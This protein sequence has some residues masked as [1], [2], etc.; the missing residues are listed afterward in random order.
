MNK[1]KGASARDAVGMP[2]PPASVVEM[3]NRFRNLMGRSHSKMQ[4][5]FALVLERLFGLIDNKM[6]GLL[7]ELEIPD[8]LHGTP[9][10]ADELARDTGADADALDRILRFLVSRDLL[11]ITSDGRYKNNKASEL[12]RDE[13]PYS[14]KG[15]VEFFASGWNWDIWGEAMHS[16]MK[17]GGAAEAALGMPFFDY[18]NDNSEA[19]TAFNAAMQSGSTMQG[20]LVQEKYDFSRSQHICDVGGGTG[21]VLG[22]LLATNP[23][24]R[25]TLFELPAV[26]E[27]ARTHLDSLRLLDR[28]EVVGGDFFES[29]PVKADIYTLFAVVH[30]WGDEEAVRILENIRR[31]MPA[32]GRVLVIEGVIPDHSHYNFSKVSDLLMLV[33]SDAGRERTGEEFDNLFTRAGFRVQ[34]VLTLPSLFRI[35]ELVTA[36]S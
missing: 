5:P 25:G 29:I 2:L 15:W 22:N 27:E 31:A 20:L 13:H 7:V 10:S 33:Y 11:G 24:L 4:P 12:L 23:Q 36:G 30:D 32:D 21:A 14:W 18:L 8:L 3:A 6:L 19:G 34:R 16:V 28:C 26:A 17:G 9:K 35:F 1:P